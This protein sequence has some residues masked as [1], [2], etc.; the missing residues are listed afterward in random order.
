VVRREYSESFLNIV[1]SFQKQVKFFLNIF[2]S[3]GSLLVIS[4]SGP[5]YNIYFPIIIK[6]IAWLP[7]I[8]SAHTHPVGSFSKFCIISPIIIW[9]MEKIIRNSGSYRFKSSR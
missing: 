7:L 8:D 6:I 2:P 9:S 4:A 3:C 5:S 1:E